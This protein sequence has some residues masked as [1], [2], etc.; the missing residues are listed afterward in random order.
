MDIQVNSTTADAE[1]LNHT[2]HDLEDIMAYREMSLCVKI[3]VKRQPKSVKPKSA[4]IST[5]VK[6]GRVIHILTHQI[7]QQKRVHTKTI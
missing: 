1:I 5:S 6:F 3:Y 7:S 4:E 2:F